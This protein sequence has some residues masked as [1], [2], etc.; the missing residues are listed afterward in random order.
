[1]EVEWLNHNTFQWKPT[2]FWPAHSYITVT[3]GGFKTDNPTGAAVVGVASI[4]A[5]TFTRQHRRTSRARNAS[6]DGQTQPPHT[7]RQLQRSWKGSKRRDG[8]AHPRDS[9][10]FPEGYDIIAQ[11]AERIT[12]SGVY[13]HSA[14]WSVDSQGNANVSHGCMNLSPDNAAWY[15]DVVHVGDPVIVQP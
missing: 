8:L 13:V 12:S 2:G 15:Y 1:V 4:S 6:F 3:L 9:A 7:G 11:Y 14:T 5:H 10:Q